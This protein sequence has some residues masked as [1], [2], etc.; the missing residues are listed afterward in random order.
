M[1]TLQ[2]LKRKKGFTLVE[3]IVVIAIIGVL[4]A[5]LIPTMIG[6][7]RSATVTSAD[8]TADHIRKTV[9]YVLQ[10]LETKGL[11]STGSGVL[12]AKI[13]NVGGSNATFAFVG[14][15]DITA[16]ADGKTDINFAGKDPDGDDWDMTKV[17]T[18]LTNAL[19]DDLREA[20]AGETKI[21]IKGGVCAQISYSS[22]T[23]PV[24]EVQPSDFA[25]DEG[26]IDGVLVGTNPKV[27][28]IV[29]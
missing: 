13:S 3:L 9:A 7:V 14:A 17:I 20:K 25:T 19:N 4:A 23:I 1:K 21:V 24:E 15:P 5:I 26:F 29:S 2:S 28:K 10:D 8:Q 22:A 16:T 18:A 27:Y 12:T 6:Y 11:A